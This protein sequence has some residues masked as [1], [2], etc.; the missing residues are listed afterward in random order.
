MRPRGR[1]KL[2]RKS[3]RN[4]WGAEK[5]GR[6]DGDGEKRERDEQMEISAKVKRRGN[7]AAHRRWKGQWY[8]G[9]EP[10]FQTIALRREGAEFTTCES[11]LRDREGLPWKKK[12]GHRLL[13]DGHVD[14]RWERSKQKV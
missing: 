12:A 7:L 1:A 4:G 13:G 11:T 10:L 9:P 14:L 3:P 2:D 8:E 5:V 6:F